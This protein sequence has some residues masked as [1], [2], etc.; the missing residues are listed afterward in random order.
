VATRKGDD[1]TWK[2]KEEGAKGDDHMGSIY[3]KND[4]L[5]GHYRANGDVEDRGGKTVGR[6]DSAGS[7]YDRSGSCVG[8]V[9]G[10]GDISTVEVGTL[11][12]L[13]EAIFTPSLAA[14]PDGT[15]NACQTCPCMAADRSR[16]RI[17]QALRFSYS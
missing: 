15:R 5:A 10:Y 8:R 11:G 13:L 16:M 9:D 7:V 6:V 12:V 4:L 3:D 2:A 1:K 14:S 17:G